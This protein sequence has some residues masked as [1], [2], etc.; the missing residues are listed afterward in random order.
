LILLRAARPCPLIQQDVAPPLSPTCALAAQGY[1]SLNDLTG[2]PASEDAHA[3]SG[4]VVSTPWSRNTALSRTQYGSLS[5]PR[6]LLSVNSAG[7]RTPASS[8]PRAWP[9]LETVPP[10]TLVPNGAET[11]GGWSGGVPLLVERRTG[12]GSHR[13]IPRG[14]GDSL[15][16]HHLLLE[17]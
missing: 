12:A 6:F 5:R 1:T 17:S 16:H 2:S 11:A 14:G 7:C 13:R 4:V 15:I 10:V 9:Y 3:A 8:H